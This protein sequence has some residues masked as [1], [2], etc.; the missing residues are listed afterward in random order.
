MRVD[1]IDDP[2]PWRRFEAFDSGYCL[3]DAPS[4]E[5]QGQW[6]LGTVL[7]GRAGVHHGYFVR[8]TVAGHTEEFIGH[9]PH[10]VRRALAGMADTAL[11]T[12]FYVHFIGL[13]DFF[14]ERGS[15][16]NTGWGEV[17]GGAIHM[18]EPSTDRPT[19]R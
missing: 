13:E 1:E 6:E 11:K 19:T 14:L 7:T 10:S 2:R 18:M 17:N 5:Q 8:L 4:G 12:G 9:H 15:S 3:V 16:W